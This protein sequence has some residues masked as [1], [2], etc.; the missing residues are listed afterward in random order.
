M[1]PSFDFLLLFSVQTFVLTSLH[2]T[3]ALHL[4]VSMGGKISG[5]SL[6]HD[7]C[8]SLPPEPFAFLGVA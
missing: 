7:D 3:P 5:V 8:I 4:L 6:W 1:F 2:D